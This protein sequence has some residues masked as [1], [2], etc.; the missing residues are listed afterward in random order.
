M[1]WLN[2]EGHWVAPNGL[3]HAEGDG[4]PMPN[5]PEDAYMASGAFNQIISV[6]PGTDI[7]FT[8]IGWVLDLEDM[9]SNEL[10][11]GLANLILE[12]RLDE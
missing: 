3:G 7:V 10:E 11:E 2:R 1:W 6:D 12:A 8:R 9:A 5:L 4:K